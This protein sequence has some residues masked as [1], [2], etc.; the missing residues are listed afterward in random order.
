VG[1]DND[2]F[3]SVSIRT[4]VLCHTRM[5]KATPKEHFQVCRSRFFYAFLHVCLKI[6]IRSI[7]VPR[8]LLT[9]GKHVILFV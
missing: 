9:E 2:L 4:L 5:K 6:Y 7:F 8:I 3:P 1:G